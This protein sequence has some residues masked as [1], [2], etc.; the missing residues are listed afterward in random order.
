MA[1]RLVALTGL[2]LA[3]VVTAPATGVAQ[4]ADTVTADDYRAAEQFL[5]RNSHPLVSGTV[6]GVTWMD[7]GRAWYRMSTGEGIEYVVADSDDGSRAPA[8][9]HERLAVALAEA[10]GREID[11]TRIPLRALELTDGTVT[12]TLFPDRSG[13]AEDG[14]DTAILEW[15]CDAEDYTCVPAEGDEE[16]RD[17]PSNSV[18]SPDGSTAV[19]IRDHDLWAM[20]LSSGDETQLTTDGVEDF[21]YG[22][23]NAG[24]IRRETPVVSW[25]PDSRRI[26]TFQH[27]G[28]GV[29]MQYLVRTKVGEPELEA[30]R[31]PLPGDSV[32]FRIHRVVIDVNGPDAPEVVRL[33]MPPDAHRSMVNDHVACGNRL[34]DLLWYPDGSHFAFVSSSRDHKHAWVRVADAE[35]GDVRTLFEETS[36]TQIGDAGAG[37]NWHLLPESD[38][39]I[40]WSERHNWVHLYLYDLETGELKNRITTGSG[41][42][43]DVV[44]VDE[45]ERTIWFTG[46]G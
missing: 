2:F 29:S 4:E 43:I 25:S 14:A 32:I 15:S 12:I 42:V 5:A 20:D 30:W 11:A 23:N 21:G 22:T 40:W 17:P 39:L 45:D 6:S 9:D 16:L 38:E 3:L 1:G 41:N 33:D 34:C 28:R 35:T 31:Y 8:F 27:D 10:T 7:D 44:H 26:A 18:L 37:E 24:W 36:E 46:Q 19:F 13:A